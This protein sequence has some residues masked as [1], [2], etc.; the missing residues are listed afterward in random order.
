M[1]ATPNSQYSLTRKDILLVSGKRHRTMNL[2]AKFITVSDNIG[3][4]WPTL[5]AANTIDYHGSTGNRKSV[6]IVE[7]IR[8]TKTLSKHNS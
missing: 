1:P 7:Y 8:Y 5:F 4:A 3:L 6:L 2:S